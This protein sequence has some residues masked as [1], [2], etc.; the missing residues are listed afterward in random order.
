MGIYNPGIDHDQL[1]DLGLHCFLKW[2]FVKVKRKNSHAH[3]AIIN[4][5][6]MV[7]NKTLQKQMFLLF[8]GFLVCVQSMYI[9]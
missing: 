3:R 8:C 9:M 4:T 5:M 6:N 2:Y 7:I 1:S